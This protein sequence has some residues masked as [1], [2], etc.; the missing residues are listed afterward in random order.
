[1]VGEAD[2]IRFGDRSDLLGDMSAEFGDQ[3]GIATTAGLQGDKRCDGLSLQGI[4]PAHHSRLHHLRVAVDCGFD[5]HG[6]EAMTAHVDHVVDPA[7]HPEVAIGIAASAVTGEVHEGSIGGANLFPVALPEALGIAVHRAQHP[8]PRPPHH[9][10]AALVGL[11][12][13][14][15]MIHHISDDARQRQGGGTRFGGG[16][17]WQRRDHHPARLGLPPGIHHRAAVATDHIPIPDPG[18]WIDRLAHGAE[19]AQG[20]LVVLVGHGASELLEG[21]DR[22]WGRVEDRA[23][24][25]LDH[26][27]EGARLTGAGSP[28][29]HHGGGAI[30]EGAIHDV[31]V[32]G[33]PAHI[34]G[35]PMDVVVA[36]V[37]DPLEGEVD[38]EVVASGGMHHPLRFAGGA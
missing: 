23:A 21:A 38:P 34:S 10:I 13:I 22:R 35:A 16:G 30:G 28:L 20:R 37:E 14:P 11:L 7:H 12:G 4:R 17:S 29:V 19:D 24:V 33:D 3:R 27:P 9:E 31:A 18:L 36:D 32:A 26:L 2:L 8:R 25:L 15:F 6:A 5:L 1:M